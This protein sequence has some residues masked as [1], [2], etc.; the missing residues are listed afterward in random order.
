MIEEVRQL[1]QI[2]NDEIRV[3]EALRL[4]AELQ[5]GV[6]ETAR[7]RRESIKR[8][9]DQG[10]SMADVARLMGVSRARVAQLKDAGPAPERVFLGIESIR[11]AV[12]ERPGGRRLVARADA[13]TG[14]TV[15]RLAHQH[16]LKADLEYIPLG[17]EIDLNREGLVVV[18]GPETSPVTAAALR[19]D[20]V[21]DFS[22]LGDGRWAITE[23]ETGVSHTSP[24]D[25]P[26]KPGNGDVAFLGR[27]P[28]PDGEG[29][30]LHIAGVHA[31]GSLG[32][33]HYLQ[34]H[35]A[36]LY[37]EVGMEPFS[38]VIASEHDPDTEEIL[39]SRALTPPLR[40]RRDDQG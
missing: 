13:A 39:S 37:D 3:R 23:R 12:P 18:C 16:G 2:E 5:E 25:D 15:I 28:R 21:L 9:R 32:A 14:Q 22:Q 26:V 17:G 35:L 30:F 11:V 7:I 20:P 6:R 8:L 36:E 40:H 4:M 10:H 38:M 33:A 24:T 34:G 31:I 27:H 29:V 19:A 1:A